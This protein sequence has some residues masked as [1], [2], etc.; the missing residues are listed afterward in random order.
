MVVTPVDPSTPQYP[1]VRLTLAE[2]TRLPVTV[3]LQFIGG[4]VL[5]IVKGPV[6]LQTPLEQLA[7]AKGLGHPA[8]QLMPLQSAD[9]GGGLFVET[10]EGGAGVE[11]S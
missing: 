2:I 9:C 3:T 8:L 10:S 4:G 6:M 1:M 11:G 7:P 5:S